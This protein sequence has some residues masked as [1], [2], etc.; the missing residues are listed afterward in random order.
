MIPALQAGDPG[1]IPGYCVDDRTC[2][3]VKRLLT[4]RRSFFKTLSKT[5]S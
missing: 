4:R 2:K 3:R 1:A 5:S